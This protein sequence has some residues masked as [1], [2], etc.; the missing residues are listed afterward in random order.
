MPCRCSRATDFFY[1][2]MDLTFVPLLDSEG[3]VAQ[4]YGAVN[5]PTTFFIDSEG[6]IGALHRG[7]MVESQI[8]GY[9]DQTEPEIFADES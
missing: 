8:E 5:F 2:E 1:E 4:L 9:L 6:I 3:L 7:P